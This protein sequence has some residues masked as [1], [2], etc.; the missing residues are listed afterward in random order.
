MLSLKRWCKTDKSL[1]NKINNNSQ[2]TNNLLKFIYKIIDWIAATVAIRLI[3][4]SKKIKIVISL[5]V[6]FLLIN[7]RQIWAQIKDRSTLIKKKTKNLKRNTNYKLLNLFPQL[8]NLLIFKISTNPFKEFPKLITILILATVRYPDSYH[9][10]LIW[11][12]KNQNEMNVTYLK[13]TWIGV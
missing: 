6:I 8:R 7:Q 13:M 2:S 12:N 11:Q 10:Y 5:E 1:I 3:K 9:N 4:T